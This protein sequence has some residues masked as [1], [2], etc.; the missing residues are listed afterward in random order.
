MPQHNPPP[1]KG[2]AFNTPPASLAAQAARI[3]QANFDAVALSPSHTNGIL[4]LATDTGWNAVAVHKV[5]DHVRITE[6]IGK[7]WGGGFT[8]GVAAKVTW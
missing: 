2:V 5:N 7:D 6:W 3:V 4:V 8:G 1:S